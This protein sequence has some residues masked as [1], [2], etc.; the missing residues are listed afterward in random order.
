MRKKFKKFFR[1]AK[2]RLVL[3]IYYIRVRA[4]V[5]I[6]KRKSKNLSIKLSDFRENNNNITL[7]IGRLELDYEL[8]EEINNR[9]WTRN[10]NKE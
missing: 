4:C 1:E 6:D 8:I 9:K 3:H 10:N 7:I 2:K 5:Y